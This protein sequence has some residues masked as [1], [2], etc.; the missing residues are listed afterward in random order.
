MEHQKDDVIELNIGGQAMTTTRS[1]LCQVEGSLLSSM[2]SGRWDNSM[3][4]DK[5]GRIFLDF[6]PT[7]FGYIL[8]YLRAK[9]IPTADKPAT[10][11]TVA[12]NQ[13]NNYHKLIEYLGLGDEMFPKV[14][15]SFKEHSSGIKLEN[16]GAVAAYYAQ[17]IQYSQYSQY[18]QPT[19]E[20]VFGQNTYKRGVIR[21]RLKIECPKYK[22]SIWVGMMRGD[23]T[24]DRIQYY[25]S[26]LRGWEII[27]NG[28][29][30][31]YTGGECS[32]LNSQECSKLE[33]T[34]ELILDYE[35]SVLYLKGP[36]GNLIDKKL[37]EWN[38][39]R[40]FVKFSSNSRT[41]DRL[42]GGQTVVFRVCILGCE[43]ILP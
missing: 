5:D 11:P 4:R 30:V 31:R 24:A 3:S 2:F 10:L 23:V 35:K 19:N 7:Y 12:S 33:Y 21:L 29:R 36:D 18:S 22:G 9:K 17:E 41:T 43:N 28:N 20:F 13:A 42:M 34:I 26:A 27:Q 39:W 38:T 8:D 37:P 25:V 6:N 40:L 32:Y 1:T 14:T 15:E 16:D